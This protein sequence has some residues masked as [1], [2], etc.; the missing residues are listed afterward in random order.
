MRIPGLYGVAYPIRF[1]LK[2]RGV[3]GRVGPLEGIWWTT[4]GETDLDS[5]SPATVTPGDGR[6]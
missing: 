6:S 1:A 2:R 5:A 3:L 4:D